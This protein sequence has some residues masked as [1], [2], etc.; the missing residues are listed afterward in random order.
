MGCPSGICEI[1]TLPGAPEHGTEEA[2]HVLDL[3][4]QGRDKLDPNGPCCSYCAGIVI[5]PTRPVA[6]PAKTLRDRRGC[7]LSVLAYTAAMHSI[8]GSSVSLE[9]N[10]AC[11]TLLVDGKIV[12]PFDNYRVER[13]EGCA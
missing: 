6:S 3:V 2:E 1:S 11:P 7:P 9:P 8:K 10:G 12:D 13:C 4:T 5:D